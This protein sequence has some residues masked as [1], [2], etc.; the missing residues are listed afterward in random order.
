MK[1]KRV[2][3]VLGGTSKERNV[4]LDSGKACIKAIKRL[5]HTIITFDPAK[6][7]FNEI[8]KL[9]VDIIFNALHG[10]DGEDGHAQSHFEYLKI[11][12]THSGVIS[13]MH[14]MDKAVS[15]KIFLKNKII[16][17]KYFVL[18]VLNYKNKN[19]LRKLIKKNR[20]TFPVVVKPTNEGSSIGVRICKNL[21]RLNFETKSLFKNYKNLIFEK[22]I[23]GKEI[24]VAVFN[25]KALGAI[26]L[27]PKRSFYDY[28]AKY[29]KSAKTLHIMPADISKKKYKEVLKIS[30]KAHKSLKCRGVTR[31]DFKLTN[32]KFYLLEL[33][34]QPG[35]TNLSLVPEIAKYKGIKFDTLVKKMIL[36]ASIDR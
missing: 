32:N 7:G 24:Q 4:S 31:S 9:K 22:Y 6:K 26:E 17:P 35:M 27:K 34:T 23:K 1:K 20:L 13:S 33:N 18:N 25:G 29:T 8:I 21:Q 11:P 30:E 36:D 15:K 5:G 19:P 10:K 14:A 12:Y 3:V 2:L 28:K 16:T